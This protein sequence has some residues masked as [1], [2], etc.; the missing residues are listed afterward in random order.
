MVQ[1]RMARAKCRFVVESQGRTTKSSLSSLSPFIF[2]LLPSSL[3]T[4]SDVNPPHASKRESMR[5]A[6]PLLLFSPSQSSNLSRR[7]RERKEER[8]FIAHTKRFNGPNT[9]IILGA[10]FGDSVCVLPILLLLLLKYHSTA[11]TDGAQRPRKR[12][13]E[14]PFF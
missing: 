6:F 5:L 9:H 10:H 8:C 11:K 12:W 2:S 7:E 3:P 13:M 14:A 1:C 4:T